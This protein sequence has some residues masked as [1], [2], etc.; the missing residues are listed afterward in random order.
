[1]NPGPP[2]WVL[3]R[4]KRILASSLFTSFALAAAAL[5]AQQPTS[6]P[7]VT[8][9]NSVVA[10]VGDQPITYFELRDNVLGKIQ[11]GMPAPPTAADSI[12]LERQTLEEMVEEELIVQ[13]AKDLKI[14]VTDAEIAPQVDNQVKQIRANFPS[15]AEFRAALAK[16]SLGTPEEY[17]KY[18]MDQYRRNALFEKT[19]A[20]LKQDGKIVPINVTDAEV[21]AEFDRNKQY[22]GKK[23]AS[24]TF[25]QIVIAPQPS[26][27]A[28][29]IARAKA[30]SL[31][32]EIKAGSDFE[33]I[34]KRESMDLT[35]KE[36]G[37][38]LG[39]VRRGN[40]WPEMD[41][42][43]FGSTFMAGLQPG[44]ISPVFETPAGFT[45]VRVDRVQPGEVKAHLIVIKSKI[46]SADIERTHLLA[47]S[48]AKLWR[49]GVP[50]DTLAKKYHDYAGKEET[51]ILTPF[52]RDSLPMTYQRG[53][54]GA[55]AGDIV[56]FQIA[57]PADNPTVPKFVVAQLLTVDEGGEPTLADMKQI[58][59]NEL[60]DRGGM[61]RYVDQLK[62]QTYVAILLDQN[63]VA[64]V[65]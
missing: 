11:R 62:K 33:R 4:M 6:A 35:T 15:E 23:P 50:F 42:W 56:D 40:Y 3:R 17:R 22:L 46:D 59:R 37:G 58:V 29:D 57:G 19:V 16:A 24:V 49:S 26:E 13:K 54:A 8:P 45:I 61:R 38:D 63:K 5:G 34:A 52:Y 28:K 27:K 48:V 43:L 32:D 47:D 36:T 39:W 14:D 25:K 55:K 51:S 44:N 31:Y 20:K 2:S 7:Q 41:R 53:F 64:Q 30:E 21:Q 60:A 18:L 12:A 65:P 1:M 9:L 10:V